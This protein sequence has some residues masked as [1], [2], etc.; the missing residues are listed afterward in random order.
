MGA[1]KVHPKSTQSRSKSSLGP[2]CLLSSAPKCPCIVP[3]RPKVPTCRHQACQIAGLAIRYPFPRMSSIC[4]LNA[5]QGPPAESAAH[6][7][8]F[9]WFPK[10]M[11][12]R[13]HFLSIWHRSKNHLGQCFNLLNFQATHVI[14]LGGNLG[15]L[16]SNEP[17]AT[18]MR[19]VLL[20]RL[21]NFQMSFAL[22]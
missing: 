11:L 10:E 13:S 1:I 19:C 9:T 2:Q 18:P 7:I 12:T 16:T 14:L 21:G 22:L 4:S 5:G 17:S 3:W 8:S 15:V 6:T 20:V